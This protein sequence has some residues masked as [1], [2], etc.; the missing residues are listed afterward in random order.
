MA[1]KKILL[2]FPFNLLSHYLRC[3]V[4][5]DTYN[6]AEYSIYF[7]SSVSY[8]HFVL[9]HGY[10]TFDCLQF[11][12]KHVMGCAKEFDFSWLNK[13]VLEKIMLAQVAAIKKLNADLVIGDVAPTLKMAAEITGIQYVSLLN[14][15]MTRYY[16]LNRKIS[17][18]H[19]TYKLLNG[20]PPLLV[21]WLTNIGENISFKKIQQPFNLLRLKYGLLPLPNYLCEIE[22]DVGLICDLPK[23]FP[24][25]NLPSSFQFVGPLVYQY[26]EENSSWLTDIPS[27]KK[28]ICISLGST[29]DW[30]KLG[31]LN[32][33]YYAKYTIV[34]TGDTTK[35]LS[36]AHVVSRD[37]VN[38]A[39][40]LKRSGLM[41]CH[42]G[43]GTIYHGIINQVY[44]LCLSSHFEQEWNIDALERNGYGK[45]ADSFTEQDWRNEIEAGM[46][47]Y[48][49]RVF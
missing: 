16:A 13:P 15:Y 31:F 5:A 11:D 23:L 38:L 34:A 21:V 40:L 19:F 41:I 30:T 33:S 17:K 3:L 32:D 45:S 2:F 18:T 10:K 44:M 28:V 24:Q 42:G 1:A 6:K 9:K 43:N 26:Q 8:D 27:N 7:L 4:L 22:G 20:L 12:V 36:A 49:S 35:V 47:N 46:K 48:V 39:Q 14:G 25:K 29:G 37:F